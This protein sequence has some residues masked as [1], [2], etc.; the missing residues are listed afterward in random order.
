LTVDTTMGSS[1]SKTPRRGRARRLASTVLST[2][3]T[4]PSSILTVLT[5]LPSDLSNMCSA[6]AS[7]T[8]LAADIQRSESS[9]SPKWSANLAAAFRPA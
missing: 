5:N 6:T 1:G 8:D 7:L 2:S 3:T 4:F 9:A